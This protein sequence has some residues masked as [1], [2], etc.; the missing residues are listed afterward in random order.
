MR[1]REVRGDAM[2]VAAAMKHPALAH[3]VNCQ[4]VMGAGFAKQVKA[5]FPDMF[6]LYRQA[7]HA[8]ALAPTGFLAWQTPRGG[9]VYNL[10]SQD[11]PGPDARMEWLVAS[12]EAMARHAAGVGLTEVSMVRIGCG[13]GGLDWNDV[14][15][16]LQ[17][18][19]GDILL[20]VVSPDLPG[21]TEPGRAR[22]GQIVAATPRRAHGEHSRALVGALGQG[23]Q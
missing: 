12:V 16:A 22:A 15:A 9:W 6:E 2:A 4:G 23:E 10:A 5:A 21:L 3:G 20:T 19:E 13:I 17:Q 8:G 14:R 7:C 1:V 11:T 18:A